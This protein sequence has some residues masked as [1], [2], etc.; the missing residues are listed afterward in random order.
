[1]R[2]AI[3]GDIH[4][5]KLQVSLGQLFGKRLLGQCNLWLHRRHVFDPSLLGPVLTRAM[6]FQ[7]DWLLF[8]GDLTTTAQDGEFALAA[9]MLGLAADSPHAGVLDPALSRGRVLAVPGNHDRYTYAATRGRRMEAFLGPIMPPAWPWRVAL[10]ERWQLIALDSC[11]PRPVS[12]R[13]E[14]DAPQLGRLRRLIRQTPPGMGTMVLCHYPFDVPP[15][16][17][18]RPSHQLASR[19]V[20][21]EALKALPGPVVFVHGHIHEPWHWKLP[22]GEHPDFGVLNTGSPCMTSQAFP[23]G[24][25]FW[26]LQVARHASEAAT[27]D[28][29]LR[30]HRPA[31]GATPSAPLWRVEEQ[32]WGEA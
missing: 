6:S 27:R 1:M 16:R 26:E 19:H 10:G 24:Q 22:A 11:C 13:G 9:R 7:P 14:V 17:V 3:I 12:S 21:R 30:A 31:P 2:I 23:A 15:P 5:Y 8:A 32:S 4:L 25:G 18:H 29:T 28:I 20:L